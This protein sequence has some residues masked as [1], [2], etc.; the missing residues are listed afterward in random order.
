MG[1]SVKIIHAT[2]SDGPLLI[3]TLSLIGGQGKP[4]VAGDHRVFDSV[5][6]LGF[7]PQT[8]G[9]AM[10][11]ETPGALARHL[12]AEAHLSP[13]DEVWAQWHHEACPH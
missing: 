5:L 9:L 11:L 1:G 4:G 3:E 13:L 2:D 12:G 8:S 7:C 10:R 6:A